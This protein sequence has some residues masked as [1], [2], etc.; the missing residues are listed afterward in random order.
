MSGLRSPLNMLQA[1]GVLLVLGAVAGCKPQ[2]A[3]TE[4]LARELPSDNKIASVPLGDV[5][6]AAEGMVA[7]SINNPVAGNQTAIADGQRLFK[8]MNCAGCHGYDATGGMGPD[9][10]DKYWRYGGTPGAL[11]RSI[12]EGRPQGMP[13]WG[14]ALPPQEI[15]KIVAYLATLGG[16][17]DAGL[18]H[19]SLQGDHNVTFV[20]PEI[21]QLDSLFNQPGST[22]A[23]VPSSAPSALG[24]AGGAPELAAPGSPPLTQTAVP[25]STPNAEEAKAPLPASQGGGLGSNS[26]PPAPG[27]SGSNDDKPTDNSNAPAAANPA[28]SNDQ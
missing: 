18:R 23:S 22:G 2:G 16:S 25:E 1:A 21:Q 6:G 28:P 15:W 10:T 17:Y 5:A 20:A 8:A 7:D 26:N 9:L 24:A 19:A 3:S 27:T 12:F 14:T 13:S 11:Y 4:T